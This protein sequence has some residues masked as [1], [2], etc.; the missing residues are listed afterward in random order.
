MVSIL[1]FE[2][3]DLI[4]TYLTVAHVEVLLLT[5]LQHKARLDFIVGLNLNTVTYYF[6]TLR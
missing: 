2:R 5:K 3:Y 1:L 6:V 4:L